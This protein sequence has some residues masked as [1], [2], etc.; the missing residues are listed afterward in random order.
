MKR[1]RIAVL[2]AAYNGVHWLPEQV[3][4]ILEQEDVDVALFI[5][6]DSSD[7]GTEA[8]CEALQASNPAVTVLPLGLRFGGAGK[9]F[10]RLLHDVEL[11]SFDAIS[12]ADQDD[13]WYPDKLARA[14]QYIAQGNDAYS[15]NVLAF[16][17]D[18]REMLVEK[19]QPQ[20][21]YDF[22]FEAA[23]PGCTYVLSPVLANR[24]KAF[25]LDKWQEIQDVTLHDW[26]IY[27]YA[28]SQRMQWFIDPQPSMRYRQHASNQVG[29][30]TG[31]SA[32]KARLRKVLSGWWLQQSVHIASLVG[33]D[34][35]ACVV[36][37]AALDIKSLLRLAFNAR[38][39][40]RR[41]RDR[42]YFVGLCLIL[43]LARLAGR[44]PA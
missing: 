12:L 31:G 1:P 44:K 17:P 10:F 5:S 3:T 30:N 32:M 36:S 8:W 40:R 7:D 38:Q 2:L 11:A 35:T 4:S 41:N 20:V 19:H 27:A 16:W 13:I 14:Y 42:I 28:R 21:Q 9:N 33:L 22:L 34:K 6:V 15:S 18:G 43:V 25:L 23:G 26:L 39:Y 24:F 29:V 37:W